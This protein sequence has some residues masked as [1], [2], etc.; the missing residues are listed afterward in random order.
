MAEL[1]LKTKGSADRD[2]LAKR[3]K[4]AMSAEIAIPDCVNPLRR[5]RCLQDPGLF[6]KTYFADQYR[7]PFGKHHHFMIESI[8][9]RAQY[10]GRQ[11]IAAPRGCGKTELTKGLLV[12]LILAGLVRF[13]LAVAATTELAGKI[14]KD[15][16]KKLATNDL[17][18]EDFPEVCY[19]IRALE[20]AP[21]RAGRQHVG[22]KLTGIVWT[23]DYISLP[24]VVG[25]PYGGVKMAYYGLDAAFRGANINGDRPQFVLIDDPET[26]ESARMDG[27]IADRESILDKDISG[28][29][30]QENRLSIVVITTVQNR[31]CLSFRL[32]DRKI[33]P[34][35][36]GMRFGMVAKWPTNIELWNEYVALRKADQEAGDEHGRRATQFYLA[37][38]EDMN[39]DAEMLSDHFV[40]IEVD[41]VQMVHS[42]LQQAWNSIADTNLESYKTEYQNDPEPEEEAETTGLTAGKVASRISG[43]EQHMMPELAEWITV[44]LDMGKYSS[45]WVKI[46]WWGNAI[47]CIID[48]GVMETDSLTDQSDNKSIEIALLKSLSTWR[49]DICERNPPLICMIDSGTYTQAVYQFCRSSG[50]PFFASKGWDRGR[51]HIGKESDTRKPFLEAYASYQDAERLWLYNVNTE[52]WKQWL[53]E[54]F[55]VDTF[56]ENRHFQDG[57]L[58]LFYAPNN[59]K[60]HTS[61]SHHIVAECRRRIFETGKGWITKW[62]PLSRNNHYLDATALACAGAGCAGI[63]LIQMQDRPQQIVVQ[64]RPQSV[65]SSPGRF[66]RPDGRSFIARR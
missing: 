31:K 42:A 65:V 26:S 13:P 39:A 62:D 52:Y 55:M 44:G 16:K 45:H 63:R 32:T 53:Q 28:L 12:F 14:Y 30:S 21:Q 20:G 10:G 61:F 1:T 2:V 48:Y 47:G 57:S 41:G 51:F 50:S 64:Q 37:N 23:D 54:R 11:A 46:A 8:V 56:D 33:R 7:L 22:G 38:W 59:V 60:R 24:I 29:A 6:L 15:F 36:N 40:E 3:E 66:S 5:E 9:S 43:Y 17:L 34:S 49:E 4:R 25:S 58:S 18:L 35:Y 27:Q 19:P